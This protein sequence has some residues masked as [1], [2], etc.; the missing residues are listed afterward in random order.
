MI[1]IFL[2]LTSAVNLMKPMNVQDVCF[3]ILAQ[4]ITVEINDLNQTDED[5]EK[6]LKKPAADHAFLAI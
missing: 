4:T 1:K 3:C 5:N 6:E 2:L